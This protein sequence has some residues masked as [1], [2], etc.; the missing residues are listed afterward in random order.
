MTD[1]SSSA[2]ARGIAEI[3]QSLRKSVAYSDLI[4]E[5][6]ITDLFELVPD[7]PVPHEFRIGEWV[8]VVAPDT[9]YTGLSGW[10]FGAHGDPENQEWV[11]KIPGV[12]GDGRTGP[13]P[14]TVPYAYNEI[15]PDPT[16]PDVRVDTEK[17]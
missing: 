6:V 7:R 4:I 5:D 9:T 16:M 15:E 1:T 3:V 17:S 2:F 8:T 14:A 11:V 12:G 13:H 10:I